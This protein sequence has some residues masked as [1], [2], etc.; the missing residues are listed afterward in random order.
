[1]LKNHTS[2]EHI[3]YQL[4]WKKCKSLYG[5]FFEEEMKIKLPNKGTF[6]MFPFHCQNLPAI[7]VNS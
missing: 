7:P 1:M 4:L 6:H 5:I 3:E 2:P